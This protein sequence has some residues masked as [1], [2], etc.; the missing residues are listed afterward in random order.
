MFVGSDGLSDSGPY[1][2]KHL[3]IALELK[4]TPLRLGQ[5]QM[6]EEEAENL[7]PG[8]G[9][10]SVRMFGAP[11]AGS[12]LAINSLDEH[13][14]VAGAD[15]DSDRRP[16]RSVIAE[17]EL[18][19]HCQPVAPELVITD[20]PRH[21]RSSPPS[22]SVHHRPELRAS[23][24]QM[25]QSRRNGRGR[26]LAPDEARLLHL[27][28]AL[29][30]QVRRDAGQPVPKVGVAA[31]SLNQKLT[32]DQHRPALADHVQRLRYRAVLPVRL[33]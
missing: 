21:Q 20:R 22:E 33:H 18:E 6:T 25:K 28:Q 14:V 32:N 19:R 3:G 9:Q 27:P 7:R 15:L 26:V 12:H 17:M 11:G 10:D 23:V 8:S 29:S 16:I 31:G 5:I 30:Q 4:P 13:R 24:G 1:P 2:V